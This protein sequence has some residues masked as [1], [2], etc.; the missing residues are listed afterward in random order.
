LLARILA[1][2]AT[3]HRGTND[4][5]RTI[6]ECDNNFNEKEE[7]EGRGKRVTEAYWPEILPENS[8]NRFCFERIPDVSVGARLDADCLRLRLGFS[9]GALRS[10]FGI[11]KFT[12]S[13]LGL[14]A[15]IATP[16]MSC[17]APSRSSYRS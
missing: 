6:N 3:K 17:V 2:E 5:R 15:E 9:A 7:T 13:A 8:H 11:G 4:Q 1:H 12:F 14:R 16:R 10:G